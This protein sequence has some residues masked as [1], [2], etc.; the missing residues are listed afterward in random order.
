MNK[1]LSYH[2]R[3]VSVDIWLTAAELQGYSRLTS[4]KLPQYVRWL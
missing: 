4:N 3:D 1:K 2:R